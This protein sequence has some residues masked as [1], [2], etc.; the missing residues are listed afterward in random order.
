MV[1][2]E[3]CFPEQDPSEITMKS[4]ELE[5]KVL[6]LSDGNKRPCPAWPCLALPSQALDGLGADSAV[7]M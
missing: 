3:W 1:G 6:M 7:A 4:W 5:S 2:Q